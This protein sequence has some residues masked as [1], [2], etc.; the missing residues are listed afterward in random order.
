MSN[1]KHRE[2]TFC[3]Y[4][5]STGEGM[6]IGCLSANFSTPPLMMEV[7]RVMI[8]AWK[9]PVGLCRLMKQINGAPTI[10]MAP[11]KVISPC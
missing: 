5:G 6:K 10:S 11:Q 3:E 7:L 2:P 4:I 9:I 1:Q 8:P